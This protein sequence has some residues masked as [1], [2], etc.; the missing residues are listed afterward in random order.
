MKKNP[1]LVVSHTLADGSTAGQDGALGAGAAGAGVAGVD[2]PGWGQRGL[3][4]P[5]VG[6]A[7][8]LL[9]AA[10]DRVVVGHLAERGDA[11]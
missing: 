2:G 5:D 4:A 6:V 10:A 1:Y 11:A 8:P 9:G 7:P 3:L